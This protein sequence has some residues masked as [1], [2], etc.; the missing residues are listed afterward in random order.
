MAYNRTDNPLSVNFINS[1]IS[2][3]SF[4]GRNLK[5][6]QF[7]NCIGEEVNFSDCNLNRAD[8]A[9]TNLKNAIFSN[10]D[11]TMANF[12]GAVNYTINLQNNKTKKAKFN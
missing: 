10:T 8:F 7:I 6:A 3:S 2:Y 9:G 1:R 12:V 4:F 11:I 5:K